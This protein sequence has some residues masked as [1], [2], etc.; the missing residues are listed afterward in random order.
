MLLLLLASAS[1]LARDS[2]GIVAATATASDGVYTITW[3]APVPAA[4]VTVRVSPDPS[5]APPAMKVLGTSRGNTFTAKDPVGP[6]MR[7]YFYVATTDGNGVR[8][9]TRLVPL[10]GASNFRD[11]G[12][13]P[14]QDGKHVRWGTM[15]R[16][17]ALADLT[18]R[19]YRIVDAL[20]IK[21]VN[22]LRSNEE[23]RNQ[24]TVWRGTAP[25]FLNS[26]KESTQ[27]TMRILF[28]SGTPTA[29][30][31]RA[32]LIEFYRQMP[33]VY[34]EENRAM[35]DRLV[36]GETPVIVHCTAG[37]DRTGFASALI[38]SAL[39]VPREV[40]EHDYS[41]SA[42]YRAAGAQ[43]YGE[44][45]GLKANMAVYSTAPPEVM[46]ELNKSDPAYIAAALDSISSSYGSVDAY[47]DKEMGVGSAQL[48]KLRAR[49]LEQ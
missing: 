20:N 17:N 45:P 46:D 30:S 48:A 14:T 12:G 29:A 49:Y 43:R 2:A 38:L 33:A 41:L 23:R 8:V 13:Y 44:S 42:G 47:L 11:L 10:E 18:E 5:A 40:I 25:A 36:R 3:T 9:A 21:L 35:F 31:A 6:G 34:A 37:K 15:F 1:A 39:G 19:D 4:V 7:P 22:D 32:H 26:P 28:G 24:P 16:S 27:Q